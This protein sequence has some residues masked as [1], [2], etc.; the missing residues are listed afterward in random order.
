[1]CRES[2]IDFHQTRG[3]SPS[4]VLQEAGRR[5]RLACWLTDER[6]SAFFATT[7][8]PPPGQPE[9]LPSMP[10][11]RLL[12]REEQLSSQASGTSAGVGRRLPCQPQ[13]QGSLLA[14][15]QLESMRQTLLS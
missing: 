12:D 7:S 4:A 14:S 15:A 9:R 8:Q 11:L 13:R 5:T 3:L 6:L 1:M 10:R 2:D